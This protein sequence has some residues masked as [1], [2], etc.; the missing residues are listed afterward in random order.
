MKFPAIFTSAATSYGRGSDEMDN[1]IEKSDSPDDVESAIPK[2]SLKNIPVFDIKLHPI[3]NPIVKMPPIFNQIVKKPP[4]PPQAVILTPKWT[5]YFKELSQTFNN[6]IVSAKLESL[7][8]LF[9]THRQIETH[10]QDEFAFKQKIINLW[11]SLEQELRTKNRYFIK[12]EFMNLFEKYTQKANYRL[13]K[14]AVLYRARK[15]AIDKMPI[16]V[17][18]IIDLASKRYNDYEYQKLPSRASDIWEYIEQIEQAEWEQEYID[19]F[20]LHETKF[21]GFDANKSDAPS[22]GNTEQG[23]INPAGISYLYTA[24]DMA[25]AISEKQPAIAELVSVAKIKTLKS[26]KIFDFDFNSAFKNSNLMEQPVSEMK[27]LFGVTYA[28]L[29]LFFNTISELF[30]KAAAGDSRNYY[31]TQYISEFIKSKDFDGI[32]Y[33]SSSRKNGALRY[34]EWVR[35]KQY[36]DNQGD[37]QWKKNCLGL[38]L[39]YKNRYT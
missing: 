23:R 39:E 16:E 37:Y 9:K 6:L 20:H 27:K 17:K 2:E 36:A 26:L 21:W 3:I 19:R 32:K 10:R 38:R 31:I 33:N 35:K 29:E 30:S 24:R 14:G 11:N 34:F 7:N 28:E 13:Y 22:P 4:V 5:E 18:N 25:T 8:E 12:S 1:E 15:F